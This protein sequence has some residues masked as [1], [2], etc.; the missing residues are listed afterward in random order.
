MPE[1]QNSH[2]AMDPMAQWKQWN[3]STST[4]WSNIAS[5][6]KE[7]FVYPYGLYQAWIKGVE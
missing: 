1:K 2:D 3:T 6:N 5:W 4:M 7:S